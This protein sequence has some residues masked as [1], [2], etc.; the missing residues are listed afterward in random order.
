MYIRISR[1]AW[2]IYTLK[3]GINPSFVIFHKNITDGVILIRYEQTYYAT[4]YTELMR[5]SVG[6][7][8]IIK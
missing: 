3:K 2:E 7:Y 1:S 6:L 5:N 4:R 8:S